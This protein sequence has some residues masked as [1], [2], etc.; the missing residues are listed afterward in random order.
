MPLL[1]KVFIWMLPLTPIS[2]SLRSIALNKPI[3]PLPFVAVFIWVI[4]MYYFAVVAAN[5]KSAD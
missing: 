2:H 3:S 5:K 1:V 4:F